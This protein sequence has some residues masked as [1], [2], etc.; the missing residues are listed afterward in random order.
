MARQLRSGPG[1]RVGWDGSALAFQA[2]VGADDW[3]VELT[4]AE[5]DEFCRFAIQLSDAIKQM[6][7]ELMEEEA[8]ACEAS[9]DR[10]WMEVRG[11][12]DAYQLSFIALTGRRAE[13]CWSVEATKEVLRAVQMVQVF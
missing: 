3:A 4:Q 1:W 10:L 5:F 12:P 8:I 6:R 7:P 13:G 2:L 11:Y 9:S